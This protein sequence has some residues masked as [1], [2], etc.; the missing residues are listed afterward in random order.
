VSWLPGSGASV[1]WEG[2]GWETSVGWAPVGGASV[3]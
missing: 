1:G 3:G 2:S